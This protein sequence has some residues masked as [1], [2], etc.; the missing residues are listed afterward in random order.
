MLLQTTKLPT[1]ILFQV[2]T[3]FVAFKLSSVITDQVQILQYFPLWIILSQVPPIPP[4]F[5]RFF[6]K[7][8]RGAIRRG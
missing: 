5:S 8:L 3:L 2:L 7:L 1:D 6:Q 4:W